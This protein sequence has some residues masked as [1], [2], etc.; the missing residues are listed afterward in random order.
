MLAVAVDASFP[1]VQFFLEGYHSPY[2]LDM[3]HESGGLLVCVKATIQSCQLSLLKF[4]FKI[5]ASPVELNQRKEKWL[6]ISI[7]IYHL[8][9]YFHDF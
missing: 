8:W 4:Q 5:Q 1:P 2:R 7:Y 3:S 6:V 9:I